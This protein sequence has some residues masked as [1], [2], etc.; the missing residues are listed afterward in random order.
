MD[1]LFYVIFFY[2]KRTVSY[3]KYS[4]YVH[5]IHGSPYFDIRWSRVCYKKTVV[6]YLM[7]IYNS[8]SVGS[9]K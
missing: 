7:I 9:I 3:I 8:N 2:Y 1:T 6:I 4:I 5:E